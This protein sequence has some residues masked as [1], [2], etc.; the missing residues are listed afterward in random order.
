MN[1]MVGWEWATQIYILILFLPD[2]MPKY[3]QLLEVLFGKLK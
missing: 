3:K 1:Y 2:E